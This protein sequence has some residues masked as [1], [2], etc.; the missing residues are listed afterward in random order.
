MLVPLMAHVLARVPRHMQRAF[1][2]RKHNP[3]QNMMAAVDFDLKFTY[4]LI[5]WEGSTHDALILADAIDR[6]D[7]FTVPKG[8]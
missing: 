3:T 7:G 5:G 8:N 2:G 4:V 6:N 1:R